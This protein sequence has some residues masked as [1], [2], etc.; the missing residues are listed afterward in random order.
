LRR[1]LTGII[2]G[3]V[4]AAGLFGTAL[5]APASAGPILETCK[6]VGGLAEL[7]PGVPVAK[8]NITTAT[9]TAG[10]NVVTF[11]GG[12][13]SANDTLPYPAGSGVTTPQDFAKAAAG[14][15]FVGVIAKGAITAETPTSA[16]LSLVNALGVPTGPDNAT[17]SGSAKLKVTRSWVSQIYADGTHGSTVSTEKKCSGTGIPLATESQ[18]SFTGPENSSGNCTSL[19]TATNGVQSFQGP[20][21]TN[22]LNASL[23]VIGTTTGV[24]TALSDGTPGQET[25]NETVTG[26]TGWAIAPSSSTGVISFAP[27]DPSACPAGPD[28]I[29]QVGIAAVTHPTWM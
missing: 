5:S 19:V 24:V 17:V 10:S 12:A 28:T 2:A 21:T 22:W 15:S 27:T 13:L 9:T 6:K 16:T 26:S 25:L 14:G 4:I 20:Y 7:L 8:L 29:T 11:T 23:V 3:A 18:T 1:Y